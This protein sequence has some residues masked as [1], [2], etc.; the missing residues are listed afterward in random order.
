MI[1][2]MVE[3][4]EDVFAYDYEGAAELRIGRLNSNDL[5]IGHADVSR[6]HCAI[7]PVDGAFLVRD[8][9]SRNGVAVNGL[10]VGA[11]AL[12]VRGDAI[13]LGPAVTVRF[14]EAP[15]AARPS[16]PETETPAA[17]ETAT[18]RASERPQA[19]EG[20]EAPLERARR[21]GAERRKVRRFQEIARYCGVSLAVL[22]V[23]FGIYR[24]VLPPDRA[25]EKNATI[26][27]DPEV[28][29]DAPDAGAKPATEGEQL[30][31]RLG[32]PLTPEEREWERIETSP[33]DP[34]ELIAALDAFAERFPS[35]PRSELARSRATLLRKTSAKT[36]EAMV[37]TI[38]DEAEAW[39]ARGDLAEAYAAA[40]LLRRLVPDASARA[41]ALATKVEREAYAR[42]DR[43]REQARTLT[44]EGRPLDALEVVAREGLTY[45]RLPFFPEVEAELAGLK[46][47]C[48][49][50]LPPSLV[51][52]SGTDGPGDGAAARAAANGDVRAKVDRLKVEAKLALLACDFEA[53]VARLLEIS[54]LPLPEAERLE[55]QWKLLD[56]RRAR[57]LFQQLLARIH[58]TEEGRAPPLQVTISQSI[59][60]DVVRADASE[61]EIHAVIA[62]ETGRPYIERPWRDLPPAQVLELFRQ[63]ELGGDDL[64]AFAAYA[65]ESDYELEAYRALI[66]LR[67]RGDAFDAEIASLI[68]R[69]TGEE[70]SP[71]SLVPFEGRL[72]ARH[73]K[74]ETLAQR[75]AKR[76]EAKAAVEELALAKKVEHGKKYLAAAVSLLDQ[77]YYA[78]GR[79]ILAAL[80]K[81][82]KGTAVG[83]EAERRFADVLLR[84]RPL[85][86]T[87][88]DENRV[89]LYFVAEGFVV[90]A[91]AQ[92]SFDRF[93]DQ[94]QRIVLKAE[95]FKEYAGYVNLYALNVWSKETGVDREPGNVQKDTAC[96][97]M[98]RN[99]AFTVDGGLVRAF[100]DRYPGSSS[101]GIAIGNDSATVATGGG[102]VVAVVKGMIDVTAHELGHALGGLGDEY[103]YD[104]GGK[105]PQGTGRAPVPLDTQV[106]APNLIRGNQKDDMRAKA[107]W[108]HWIAIGPQNWTKRTVDLFEG[109]D[110]TPFD[111]WRPQV[112][113]RMRSSMS[114]FCCV[115]MERMVL[116]IYA[117]ARPIDEVSPKPEDEV[118]LGGGDDTAVFR[119]A[120]LRPK[121][122]P[123]DAEFTL[124]E[125]P[126]AGDGTSVAP[127]QP[128]VRRLSWKA[129]EVPDGRVVYAA[130]LRGSELDEG[131]YEVTATVSDPTPWVA[132]ED[133]SLLRDSRTWRLRVKK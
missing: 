13:A 21:L 124:V 80:A 33:L 125:M 5:P 92:R 70:V 109:G 119:I 113:C 49:L 79:E 57:A 103:D 131:R 26:G 104:P 66:S 123:L 45:R 38:S 11:E 91:D 10:K 44:A 41:D 28:R 23:A 4:G 85:V 12:L 61:V 127:R 63:L 89:S 62:G 101:V 102:G 53:A 83:T 18:T 27:P 115:C 15:G 17:E 117:G 99:G 95:P 69:R 19:E 118:E 64:L 2:L 20:A 77:G 88:R 126:E 36:A 93:A 6:V 133:R 98:I 96:G 75:A 74:D 31:A 59:R 128:K 94:C 24:Y 110:R 87:G 30:L 35:S 14:G 1:R 78:E 8:L 71:D 129:F 51:A 86:V 60:G 116:A 46:R 120:A 114:E 42:F 122:R 16:A 76:A 48:E 100:C 132:Q 112:D 3:A 25:A 73:V 29:R 40:S 52:G 97:G 37:E 81:Q 9:G 22:L 90:D 105:G 55:I 106:L 108:R 82:L 72:V 68:S 43:A 84:R 47:A 56:A 58:E 65:F 7:V 34:P 54:K 39:L 50:V 67:E 121:S 107:P 32:G 130:S 111:V